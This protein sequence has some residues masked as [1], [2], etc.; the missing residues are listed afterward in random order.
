MNLS[1]I[2]SK[3]IIGYLAFQTAA[4][5]ALGQTFFDLRNL[6]R[7]SAGEVNARIFDAEDVPL[8]GTNFLA[9]LWGSAAPDSLQPLLSYDSG[10]RFFAPFFLAGSGQATPGYFWGEDWM[11]LTN[12]NPMA[13]GWGWLQVRVWDKRLGSTYEEVAA[14]GL[15]GYGESPLFYAVGSP[16]PFCD[17]PCP[18]AALF[19][20]Q[21]FKLRAETAVL[22]RQIRRQLQE[23]SDLSQSWQNVG[24]Q[25]T[26]TSATNVIGSG[27]KFFRVAGFTQ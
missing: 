25:T 16:G 22:M 13:W 18:G 17:P 6:Y 21:S 1:A 3:L 14:R 12:F 27:M 2:T 10:Q 24:D 7:T 8:S 20:L 15:G 5:A 4:S 11:M 26:L 23:A 9:E 19:G